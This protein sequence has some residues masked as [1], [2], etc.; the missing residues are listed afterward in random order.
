M[1]YKTANF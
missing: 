1:C